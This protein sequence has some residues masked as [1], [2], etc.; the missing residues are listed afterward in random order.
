VT[1]QTT[2]RAAG[3]QD[4][5][6]ASADL[7]LAFAQVGAL[8]ALGEAEARGHDEA[9]VY[10][11]SIRWGALVAGRLHRLA[12]LSARGALGDADQ[13]RYAELE[14][15]LR[16]LGPLLDRLSL[17]RPPGGSGGGPS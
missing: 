10:D 8:R 11:A 6:G 17:P 12:L 4:P 5:R 16:A 9:R 15:E 2:A 3:S 7:D 1:E 14:E 13:A